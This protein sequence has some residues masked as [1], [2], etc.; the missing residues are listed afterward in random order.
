MAEARDAR[1]LIDY[2]D[3]AAGS[4]KKDLLVSKVKGA[5]VP[6]SADDF[7][8][9][10]K[11]FALGLAS[12][13][14]DRGERVAILSENRPE[15]PMT[16]FATLALGGMTV[17][18]Y[19]TYLAPQVEYI[20]KDSEA[21]VCVVSNEAELHKV[22]EVRDRCTALKEV[23]LAEGPIPNAQHVSSFESVVHRGQQLLAANPREWDERV[24]SVDP[25]DFATII[26]TSGTTGEP[27]GAVLS[28]GN[29]VS[30]VTAA[31]SLF[32]VNESMVALS[33]LPLSH[34]FERMVDYL[35]FGRRVTIAYAESIDKLTENFAEVKP[36]VFAAVPRVYEKM[37]ARVNANVEK[38]PPLRRKIFEW[39]VKVGKERLK[40]LER[41]RPVPGG[42]EFKY[43]LADKL[44]FSKIKARLGGRFLF[45]I[46]GGAPLARD[47]AEFFWGA[48]VKIFEGY[49]LTETSPVLSCNRPNAFRLGSVGKPVPGVQVKVA[50]DGEVIAKGPN[51]MEGYWKKPEETSKVFDA[52][53]WFH[54]GDVGFFD[55]D[56]FLTLTDRKKEILVNAYGK[57]IAPAPIEAALKMTRYV[58][59]AVLIGDRRKFLS[60]LI[61]PS[62]ER[63]ESWAM[64]NRIEYRSQEDLVRNPKVRALFQQLLDI[65]NGDEPSERRIKAFA[66]LPSDFSIEGG[67]LTPTLKVKRRV[68]DRKYGNLIDAMYAAAEGNAPDEA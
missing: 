30:N 54:T 14:V 21:K 13:G 28:H 32:D 44:V 48:G 58:A 49:G 56:G 67:E 27:K 46:S 61:V 68:I 19:T 33:F 31:G 20:L 35:Y 50:A 5:W 43:K 1:T 59:S 62:F 36:H 8:A 65:V 52:D 15:W 64:E 39:G 9:R 10:T 55:S 53:G 29:F 6:I 60:A 66:L 17:P 37:L 45:A 12:L 51:I 57:N 2:F 16:D 18:I 11:A 47:V 22:M 23:V 3:I 26:Y 38:A 7:A 24:S 25:D 4:G 41:R 40:H 42:L 34:V 63:V